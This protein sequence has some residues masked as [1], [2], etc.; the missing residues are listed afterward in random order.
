MTLSSPLARTVD[1]DPARNTTEA[2][3]AARFHPGYA[4]VVGRLPAGRLVFHGLPFDLGPDTDA[5]RWVLVDRPTTI[6]LSPTGPASHVVVA[7]LCDTWR[8]DTGTRPAGLTVGH[9]VPV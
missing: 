5:S 6:D 4:P 9:V 8:D 7:H 2:Q 1:L 3:L